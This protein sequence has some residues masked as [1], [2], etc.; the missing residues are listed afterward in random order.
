MRVRDARIA[1]H[2]LKCNSFLS[3]VHKSNLV[4][5]RDKKKCLKIVN[6]IDGENNKRERECL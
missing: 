4:L 2:N 6:E 3:D 5:F 1:F